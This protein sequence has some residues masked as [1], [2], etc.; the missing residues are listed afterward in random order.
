MF[1]VR[2][3]VRIVLNLAMTMT[4]MIVRNDV[5][6][7]GL[8]LYRLIISYRHRHTH[9]H[10]IKKMN[11]FSLFMMWKC[12][13]LIFFFFLFFCFGFCIKR[14]FWFKAVFRGFNSKCSRSRWTQKN[15]SREKSISEKKKNCTRF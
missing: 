9:Y 4:M 7:R 14:R 12:D 8:F 5:L 2:S 13:W 10:C 1:T 3:T 15:G 11:K 6:G